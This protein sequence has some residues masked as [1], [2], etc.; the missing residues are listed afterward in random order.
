[1][2]DEKDLKRILTRAFDIQN[3]T[4]GSDL[5]LGSH[6]K[7]S[8]EEIEE[9]ASESGLSP[10]FVRQAVV[11]FEGVPIEAPFFLDTGN[12]HEIELLGFAKGKLDQQTWAEMRSIIEDEFAT[13]GKVDRRPDGIFWRANPS[14]LFRFLKRNRVPTVEVK[15]TDIRSVIRIKKR[16]LSQRKVL[17]PAWLLLA[18]AVGL[19][20]IAL[21]EGEL[22]PLVFG[23][24]SAGLSRLFF[25]WYHYLTSGAKESLRE[26]MS[27]LQTII[28]R[29]FTVSSQESGNEQEK[30]SE[31][32]PEHAFKESN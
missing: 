27:K 7:L 22:A 29:R 11:E 1:M 25:N 32:L 16:L 30:Y 17:L 19:T 2:Y 5:V 10:E 13:S 8:L 3:R 21:M 6:E 26:T 31:T 28:T 14:G 4:K 9:I 15:S 20:A 24:L 23:I 18:I 12:R